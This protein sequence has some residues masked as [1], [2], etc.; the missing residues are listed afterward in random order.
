MKMF[1]FLVIT[2][3]AIMSNRRQLTGGIYEGTVSLIP[4]N[5]TVLDESF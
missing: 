4:Y 5:P 3:V 2:G 1:Y